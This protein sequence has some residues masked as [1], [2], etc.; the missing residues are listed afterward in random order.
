M[1]DD[2]MKIEGNINFPKDPLP[3]RK[4]DDDD[5]SPQLEID[6]GPIDKEDEDDDEKYMKDLMEQQEK[7]KNDREQKE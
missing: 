1:D 2:R 5:T 6:D 7:D 4:G 3:M